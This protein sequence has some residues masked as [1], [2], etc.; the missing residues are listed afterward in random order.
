MNRHLEECERT[1]QE[2]IFKLEGQRIQLEEVR[3]QSVHVYNQKRNVTAKRCH[4][5]VSIGPKPNA[6]HLVVKR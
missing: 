6:L 5:V 2:R 4:V 1:L 3:V